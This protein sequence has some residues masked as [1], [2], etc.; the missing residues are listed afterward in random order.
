VNN[1]PGAAL[2]S[3]DFKS[4]VLSATN[5][6]ELIGRT[7]SLKKRGKNYIGLCPFH[8]EKTP[9]FN[10]DPTRQYFRCFGCG[11]KGNAIDFVIQRDRVEFIDALKQLGQAAGL[12]MPQ[13]GQTKEKQS[14]RSALLEANSSAGSFF[15]KLLA[16][17]Q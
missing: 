16:N 3:N 7:V 11:A 13:F 10:V 15:E 2:R 6:V 17:P 8:S 5:L 12:E 14:Q 1:Q 9:S 4:A